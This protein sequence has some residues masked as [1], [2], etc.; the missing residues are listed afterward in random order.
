[1]TSKDREAFLQSPLFSKLDL[2]TIKNGMEIVCVKKGETVMAKK[3]FVRQFNNLKNNHRENAKIPCGLLF[4][5]EKI[6]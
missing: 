5:F 4:F 1:M 2:D 6:P 3:R